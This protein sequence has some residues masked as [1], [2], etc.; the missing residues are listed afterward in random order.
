MED[1]KYPYLERLNLILRRSFAHPL[2]MPIVIEEWLRVFGVGSFV[3]GNLTR[4]ESW[5]G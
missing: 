3:L 1:D 2:P 4:A 5:A